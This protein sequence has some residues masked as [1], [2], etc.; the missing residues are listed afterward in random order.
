MTERLKRDTVESGPTTT[1]REVGRPA[2]SARSEMNGFARRVAAEQGRETTQMTS[3][4]DASA[5]L[6]AAAKRVES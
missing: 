1:I 5:D 6:E 4:P 2:R 3:I